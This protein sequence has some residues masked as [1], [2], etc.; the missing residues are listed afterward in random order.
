MMMWSHVSA[1]MEEMT[2]TNTMVFPWCHATQKKCQVESDVEPQWTGCQPDPQDSGFLGGGS[3]SGFG[4]Q[5]GGSSPVGAT[6]SP[7]L[8]WARSIF[9]IPP[10][11][12][13][14]DELGGMKEDNIH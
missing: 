10:P 13:M 6:A 1:G 12:L 3:L 14:V 5:Q 4:N 2:W 8:N 9:L 7:C 11:M